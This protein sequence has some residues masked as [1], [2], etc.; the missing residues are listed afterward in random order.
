MKRLVIVGA[1]VATAMAPAATA[2]A[3]PTNGDARNAAK[4]CK[5]LRSAS[6]SANFNAMF[7]GKKNAFGKCVSQAARRD[8]KQRETA[9]KNA[10]K[11][12]K[13][14]RDADPQAFKD[15]YKNLG[16]CVSEKARE[17]KAAADQSDTARVNA[18]KKCKKERAEDPAGFAQRYG[19][20]KNAFGKCVSANAKDGGGQYV[21]QR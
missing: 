11:E 10:A 13:A 21:E 8:E 6:G 12:C 19:T 14:L 15:K 2:V 16:K 4:E 3:T 17:G 5:A 20:R 7:G 18:A 9:T 1:L